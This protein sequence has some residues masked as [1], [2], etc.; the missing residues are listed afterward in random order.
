MQIAV[1]EAN[2]IQN[3]VP[4]NFVHRMQIYTHQTRTQNELEKQGV[5]RKNFRGWG[6]AMKKNK[7]E[8]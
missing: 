2:Y 4:V 7:T 3:S 6:G 8:K 5:G 1:I